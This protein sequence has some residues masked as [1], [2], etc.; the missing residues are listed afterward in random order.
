MIG[1]ANRLYR[2]VFL[3]MFQGAMG[4][5]ELMAFNGSWDQ[6]RPQL[7]A[8]RSRMKLYLPGRKHSKNG[9]PYYTFLGHDAVVALKEYLD[10]ERGNIQNGDVI[11]LNKQAIPLG[12]ANIQMA[13]T[14]YGEKVGLLK[15]PTPP[16]PKCKGET[17]RVR[18]RHWIRGERKQ[19]TSF[20][21]KA[22]REET[23]YSPEHAIS[24]HT[25]Y[26]INSHELRDIYR[27]E[28][29][30]SGAAAVCAEFFMGHDIDPN[31]YNKI[32]KL[33]PE[34]AEEQYA[35]AEPFLNIVSEDP[36]KVGL[37]RVREL[38]EKT[39]EIED[40]KRELADQQHTLKNFE[41]TLR[42]LMSKAS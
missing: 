13:I 39:L 26:G 21:C 35:K 42:T 12:K 17:I 16:C 36:R 4:C 29:Q 2:A 30:L 14:A 11:F 37:D 32:M 8:G 9:R 27:T 1:V 41:R 34:W 38:E 23:L 19:V 15:R 7:S 20:I 25:R 10:A 6:V 22:C 3:C 5:E 28:W 40:L 33:H 24:P 31:N 18:R